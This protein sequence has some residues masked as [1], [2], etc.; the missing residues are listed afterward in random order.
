MKK[1]I[2]ATCLKRF[3]P[4]NGMAWP[5]ANPHITHKIRTDYQIVC[6]LRELGVRLRRREVQTE[7]CDL[8]AAATE[9]LRLKRSEAGWNAHLGE[10]LEEL[11]NHHRLSLRLQ[12][13]TLKAF[14]AATFV[15]RIRYRNHRTDED[16]NQLCHLSREIDKFNEVWREFS[17]EDL[18]ANDWAGVTVAEEDDGAGDNSQGPSM[19]W[20]L[21]G[22]VPVRSSVGTANT[23]TSVGSHGP[24]GAVMTNGAAATDTGGVGGI[25]QGENER[26]LDD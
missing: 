20:L 26:D 24:V 12:P 16:P 8:V 15:A 11:H 25:P 13:R 3:M 4:K 5:A 19:D 14:L 7:L 10:F 18:D 21:Q 23:T 1:K 22:V 6:A 17:S 9:L 2:P